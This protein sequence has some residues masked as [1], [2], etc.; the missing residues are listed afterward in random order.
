MTDVVAPRFLPWLRTGLA[1]AIASAA[2][3]GL[4]PHDSADAEVS[5]RLRASGDAGETVVPVAGPPI[6][7][8]GP[9]DVVG[10]DPAQVV[11]HDP[12]PG[13]ADAEGIYLTQVE[14]AAPDLPWR[15]TPAAAGDN[16][17]Q[18][19]LALV[20]VERRDGVWLEER[21]AGRLPALHIDDAARELPDA[22]QCWAWAH[23]HADSDL[24]GGVA[25][26]LAGDPAAFRSRLLCPRR[27]APGR[28]WL[29]CVVPTFE[30]GRRA[31]LGLPLAP[32]LGLAWD[33]AQPGEAVLPVY[34][35]WTFRT[36]RGGDFE[37]LARRLRARELPA[38]VGRR[39]L[40]IGRPGGGLPAAPG[41]VVSFEGALLSP[42]GRARRWPEPQRTALKDALRDAL[43]Q[44]LV[45]HGVPD[46]YDA[47]DDD[48]VV[49]PP[50]YAA[51]QA[52][53]GTVPA[54]GDAP[55][56]F[57]ELTTEPQHRA[58]AGLGAAVARRDQEALM[59][60]AWRMA[61]PTVA[62]DRLLGRARWAWEV[63]AS[64]RAA[65]DSLTGPALLQI[66]GPAAARLPHSPGLTV[67]GAIDASALPPGLVSGAFRRAP[68]GTGQVAAVTV[69]ALADPVRF[70]SAWADAGPPAGAEV[71]VDEPSL[72]PGRPGRRGRR[73]A[74]GQIRDRVLERPPA[75]AGAAVPYTG[76]PRT[77]SS[78][79]Q[80][81]LPGVVRSGLEPRAAI[82]AMVEGRVAGLAPDRGQ[83]VPDRALSRPVFS[84]PMEPR[85]A[86]LS[87]EYVVPGVGT[88]PDDT[89]G[90][91]EA[92]PAF[93]EAYLAGLNHEMG[94]ELLWREFPARLGG[95]WFQRFWDTGPGGPPD[96]VPIRRWDPA[97]GLGG[98]APEDAPA[99]TLALLV[100][101]ALLRRYP[102][103][104]VY[105]VEAAWVDGRRR[106]A[107]G[108]EVRMPVFAAQLQPGVRAVGFALTVKRARGS[109]DPGKHPGWFFVLEQR[110]A[111]TRFGLDAQHADLR[112]RAPERWSN[113]SWSHL[114]P[115]DGTAPA[116][117]DVTGP[118]WLVEAGALPGNGGRD[119]WGD[120]AAAMAR[121]TFQRPV[122][123][124]IHASAMLPEGPS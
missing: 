112:G 46:P 98:N 123:V 37:S 22:R 32:G 33:T 96:V 13:T 66:A 50:A 3:D 23:V 77:G 18:P 1:T 29:A 84:T 20:V 51:A 19:W 103:T 47:L 31:G 6:R 30:A 83:P 4:A 14:L 34:H 57:G 121:I 109:T 101:G 82:V 11:R 35:S 40:D 104:R 111:G 93:V 108:G 120:D 26:A 28:P 80:S 49:G 79:T 91:L 52:G 74:P 15:F 117:V 100:K 27:L 61:A 69:A 106:E 44:D 38:G 115:A 122:R 86:A 118:S 124:L 75:Q 89:V 97:A 90:L 56:W 5:V 68:G 71:Q 41:T 107:D 81:G 63:A 60:A 48:P 8:R 110:P 39:D 54:E 9:G 99:A 64:T 73:G 102:D 70:V 95:T 12:E 94:R 113:L 42:G 55:V 65:L 58:V 116:F 7:L 62:V 2:V 87:A 92:N 72:R 67:R 16:R 119:A 43:D 17:L 21:G 88:V 25:A 53:V 10:L 45:R 76:N 36:G 24:D 78:G 114:A 105:A 59:A 85:L